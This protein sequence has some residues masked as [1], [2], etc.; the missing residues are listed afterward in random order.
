MALSKPLSPNIPENVEFLELQANR[1]GT[2][3]N[4]VRAFGRYLDGELLSVEEVVFLTNIRRTGG[5]RLHKLTVPKFNKLRSD[6]TKSRYR[7]D[8]VT[9]CQQ[10]WDGRIKLTDTQ[11]KEIQE[12]ETAVAYAEKFGLLAAAKE[13]FKKAVEE[14]VQPSNLS[15]DEV[16]DVQ[17]TLEQFVDQLLCY[18]HI[19]ETAAV[20][21]HEVFQEDHHT[22]P[23][24][25]STSPSSLLVPCLLDD[26][27]EQQPY[28]WENI[29]E[30]EQQLQSSS[31]TVPAPIPQVLSGIGQIAENEGQSLEEQLADKLA[32]MK[33]DDSVRN[34]LGQ[35]RLTEE[36]LKILSRKGATDLKFDYKRISQHHHAAKRI[37]LSTLDDLLSLLHA[38]RPTISL[39]DYETG[40][41]P[42]TARTFMKIPDA[43]K[44]KY[45]TRP[46]KGT[47]RAG[48]TTK[49][50]ATY[51]HFSLPKV[52][53]YYF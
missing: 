40:V 48:K 20:V 44:K 7:R 13:V 53:D 11:G 45:Q 15:D 33:V 9:F 24:P 21:Q 36:Q 16:S 49:K 3:R 52:H 37:P 38:Y 42:K 41:I 14:Q 25:P 5:Y 22:T 47:T 18:N 12:T 26:N 43:E 46:V 28:S 1:R 6:N 4:L 30:F 2:K 29:L 8:A 35:V 23:P 27:G 31:D 32:K 50:A 19:A 17:P 51:M 39:R 10:V 34:A